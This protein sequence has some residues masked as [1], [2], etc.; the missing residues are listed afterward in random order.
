M[1]IH[2]STAHCNLSRYAA[3]TGLP[4]FSGIGVAL[5]KPYSRRKARNGS[6]PPAC[7]DV[8]DRFPND[9][10]RVSTQTHHHFRQLLLRPRVHR[11]AAHKTAQ[12]NQWV[13]SII[14]SDNRSDCL[15]WASQKRQTRNAWRRRTSVRRARPQAMRKRTSNALQYFDV[16]RNIRGKNK[17]HTSP[18]PIADCW[19]CNQHRSTQTA[20]VHVVKQIETSKWN[21][22]FWQKSINY[23]LRP[24]KQKNKNNKNK[25]DFIAS[26]IE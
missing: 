26:F 19:R 16:V 23:E 25:T 1:T 14:Q 5:L 21:L 18:T 11:N 3:A 22:I 9:L 10:S 15:L 17:C 8:N 13:Q 2:T 7:C 12:R 4:Y 6:L 24:Q 20:R